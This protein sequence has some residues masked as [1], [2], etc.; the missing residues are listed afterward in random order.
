[1]SWPANISTVTL[2]DGP[3][4]PRMTPESCRSREER[5]MSIAVLGLSSTGHQS[6]HFWS[7]HSDVFSRLPGLLGNQLGR[8]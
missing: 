3:A 6:S 2:A 1:M 5:D 4:R 8:A 7:T